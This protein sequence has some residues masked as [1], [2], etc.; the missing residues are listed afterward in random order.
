MHRYLTLK[1]PFKSDL[2]VVSV[3]Y[4]RFKYDFGLNGLITLKW[5]A[6]VRGV[7]SVLLRANNIDN[8]RLEVMLC[9][10]LRQK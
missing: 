3:I 1:Y 2:L 6:E 8:N 9:L 5:C 10:F 4:G 7:Q